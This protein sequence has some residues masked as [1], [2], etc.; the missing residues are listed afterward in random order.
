[1]LN[2]FHLQKKMRPYYEILYWI[3]VVF[4]SKMNTIFLIAILVT[5]A[6]TNGE[7]EKTMRKRTIR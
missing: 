2:K 6:I 7:L 5:I 4:I 3:A 1:M